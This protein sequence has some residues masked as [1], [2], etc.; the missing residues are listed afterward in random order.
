[1]IMQTPAELDR[2]ERVLNRSLA[3]WD[4]AAGTPVR[5]VCLH[6][7]RTVTSPYPGMTRLECDSCPVW[8]MWPSDLPA[9]D[10][11]PHYYFAKGGQTL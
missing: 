10:L 6:P 5:R 2:A 1:M 4:R 11:N 8:A 3:F 7:D 9:L